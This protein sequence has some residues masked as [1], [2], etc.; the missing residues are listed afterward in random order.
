MVVSYAEIG[1][2][3]THLF[4]QPTGENGWVKPQEGTH[5]SIRQHASGSA[6]DVGPSDSLGAEVGLSN[7]GVTGLGERH[8]ALP[9]HNEVGQVRMFI[10][11]GEPIDAGN[12]PGEN[13]N[14]HL[15]QFSW[16]SSPAVL[17]C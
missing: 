5:L 7:P 15:C 16:I 12:Q 10:E 4:S 1:N 14:G 2:P 17:S 11:D 3:D 13:G 8:P 6:L 9:L